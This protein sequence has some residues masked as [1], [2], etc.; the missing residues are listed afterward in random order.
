MADASIAD[1]RICVI[2][3]V[4]PPNKQEEQWFKS[5]EFK[6]ILRD[7]SQTP[8]PDKTIIQDASGKE[9]SPGGGRGR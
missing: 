7:A 6:P 2:L 1:T 3:R 8:N 9:Y 4:R 5:G